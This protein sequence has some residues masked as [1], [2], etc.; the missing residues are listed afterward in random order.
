MLNRHSCMMRINLRPLTIGISSKS[1]SF[2][3]RTK[4]AY[5]ISRGDSVLLGSV[6]TG[7]AHEQPL[8]VV[9]FILLFPGPSV[10]L[11]IDT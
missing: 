2:R 11:E 1:F 5:H 8:D 3:Q 4:D 9:D 6:V 7:L 10:L